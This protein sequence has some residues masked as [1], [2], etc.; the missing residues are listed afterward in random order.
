MAYETY[1]RKALKKEDAEDRVQFEDYLKTGTENLLV[2]KTPSCSAK[3]NTAERQS[4]LKELCKELEKSRGKGPMSKLQCKKY[5]RSGA[6]TAATKHASKSDNKKVADKENWIAAVRKSYSEAV[7]EPKDTDKTDVLSEAVKAASAGC[8]VEDSE[9]RAECEN[10][11]ETTEKECDDRSREAYQNCRPWLSNED[12]KNIT[13]EDM[14]LSAE[15]GTGK[16]AMDRTKLCMEQDDKTQDELEKICETR[17]AKEFNAQYKGKKLDN[18]TINRRRYQAAKEDT[19][20]T[21]KIMHEIKR[22]EAELKQ[23]ETDSKETSD[24]VGGNVVVSK[25]ARRKA[26]LETIRKEWNKMYPG[27]YENRKKQDPVTATKSTTTTTT[28]T[29]TAAPQTNTKPLVQPKEKLTELTLETAIQDSATTDMSNQIRSCRALKNK[30]CTNIGKTFEKFELIH[31]NDD[32][33]RLK[34]NDKIKSDSQVYEAQANRLVTKQMMADGVE[35]CATSKDCATFQACMKDEAHVLTD[36]KTRAKEMFEAD[37]RDAAE[38]YI[39]QLASYCMQRKAGDE[40]KW[41]NECQKEVQAKSKRVCL[42]ES[43]EDS[44]FRGAKTEMSS[45]SKCTAEEKDD[46]IQEIFNKA[47]ERNP[48]KKSKEDRWSYVRFGAQAHALDAMVDKKKAGGSDSDVLATCRITCKNIGLCGD[49]DT[50]DTED[51][52][53]KSMPLCEQLSVLVDVRIK[54]G[55]EAKLKVIEHPTVD[56]DVES[57]SATS[58]TE[59][60]VAFEKASG[61]R[62]TESGEDKALEEDKVS[63]ERPVDFVD[64]T[65][66]NIKKTGPSQIFQT[67]VVD[68]FQLQVF[69]DKPMG[70]AIEKTQRALGGQR[71]VAQTRRILRFLANEG[72]DTQ[73]AYVAQTKT[74]GAGNET[75]PKPWWKRLMEAWA[76]V[77]LCFMCLLAVIVIVVVVRKRRKAKKVGS[78]A[79]A[80]DTKDTQILPVV[81]GQVADDGYGNGVEQ[82]QKPLRRMSREERKSLPL[83]KPPPNANYMQEVPVHVFSRPKV[84]VGNSVGGW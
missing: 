22:E 5:I 49:T 20:T 34:D 67:N 74:Q 56:V 60:S 44:F 45:L 70:E 25:K 63:G 62:P 35:K 72:S 16:R 9:S 69:D 83:M 6:Q 64:H 32:D 11:S 27:R 14:R 15:A 3:K 36:Y 2:T 29:T 1:K 52:S 75:N 59:V 71:L 55:D 38:D 23:E 18:A 13:K 78:A 8:S 51:N 65:I 77:L 66:E 53:G 58:I 33:L 61:I 17:F 73:G 28:T 12:M 30:T 42:E 48:G 19:A 84:V 76:A 68:T 43:Y 21:I 26:I 37:V 81:N 47:Q 41:K 82:R 54:G 80:K 79:M 4:C 57:N 39:M 24:D 40:K 7:G 50:F 10:D 31:E 46:C